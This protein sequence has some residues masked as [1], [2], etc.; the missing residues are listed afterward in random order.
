MI[1]QEE[2]FTKYAYCNYSVAALLLPCLLN[3]FNICCKEG[4]VLDVL[5]LPAG[6]HPP[7][8]TSSSEISTDSKNQ[9]VD[10]QTLSGVKYPTDCVKFEYFEVTN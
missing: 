6:S 3:G 4:E 1:D 7:C 8:V 2:L 5:N 10:G 9:L